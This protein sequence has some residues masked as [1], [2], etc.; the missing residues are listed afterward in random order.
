MATPTALETEAVASASE[1]AQ[2]ESIDV[3]GRTLFIDCQGSGDPTVI[4]EAGLTGDH[5]T[6]ERVQPELAQS[7]RV[8]A[9]DRANVPPSD[10]AP[11]PRTAA[12]AV[13]DLHVLMERA[14]TARPVVL[15]G[16]SMGGLIAQLYAATHP[17]DVAGLVLIESNHPDEWDQFQARLTPEQVEEDR[18]MS[19]DNTE[20][21]DPYAS[22]EEAQAAGELPE[23]PLV[24]VTAGLSEGWPPGWDPEVFDALRADQQADL[25]ARIAGG[26]QVIA[27]GSSH[28]VPSQQPQVI[29]EAVESVLADLR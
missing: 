27:E 10:P 29:V 26:R 6:W 24:V 2:G 28:H 15:V 17:G 20:G 25:A 4:L 21:F 14:E 12:D 8:C 13:D 9:Y 7:T 19:L 18:A 5:R 1:P 11:T 22:F 23:V 3:G 16:F